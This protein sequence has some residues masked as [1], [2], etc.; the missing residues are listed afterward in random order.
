MFYTKICH[1]LTVSIALTAIIALSAVPFTPSSAFALQDVAERL[2]DLR[3]THPVDE[4]NVIVPKDMEPLPPTGRSYDIVQIYPST[5]HSQSETCIIVNPNDPD[6]LLVGVNAITAESYP[7]FHQGYYYTFDRGATWDGSN[8]LPGV[9]DAGDPVTMIDLDGN[10][11]FTYITWTSGLECWTKKSTDGGV[12]WLTSVEMPNAGS[13]DKPH[14]IVDVVPAS[15]YNGN[16]YNAW[17]DFNSYPY[18]VKCSR[19]TNG[20]SSFSSAVSISGNTANY[21]AQGVNFAI[22][23]NGEVYATW[24]IYKNS[25]LEEAGNGFNVS[26]NGGASWGTAFE[27]AGLGVNGIRGYLKTTNIRVNSFPVMDVDLSN[28]IIYLIWTDDRLGDPD[29]YLTKSYDGG[30]NWI[31]PPIRVNDD[32]EGNGK[33]QWF[34]WI[35]V[36]EDGVVGIVFYD[37]RDDSQNLLTTMYVAISY[38]EGETWDNIRIMDDQFIPTPIPGCA[39]GYQGDYIG[40]AAK[41]GSFFPVWCMPHPDTRIYQAYFAEVPYALSDI[42]ISM[43]PDMTEIHRGERFTYTIS[44]ENNTD[45]DQTFIVESEVEIPGNRTLPVIDPTTVHLNPYQTKSKRMG[46][47]IPGNAPFGSYTYTAYVKDEGTQDIID[48][49]S[50]EFEVIPY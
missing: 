4:H 30:A 12:N 32:P 39:S 41:D 38:D 16:I 1:A 28:E 43:D 11:F 24:S 3:A 27:I 33:D 45:L 35:A 14:G 15:S 40:I 31:T 8:I 17:T 44:V 37:S 42:S 50:F 5:D 47:L 46:E 19:S 6:H 23:P 26:T 10:A 9:N 20:G 21:L 36:S 7:D 25:I 2:S 13:T 48:Q 22:G 29:I 49:D 34:P 18:P